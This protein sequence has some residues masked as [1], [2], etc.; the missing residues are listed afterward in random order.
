[1]SPAEE[2]KH[3]CRI[4]LSSQV[5]A[6]LDP[7]PPLAHAHS[8]PT[9]SSAPQ[10]KRR[11]GGGGGH[12]ENLP[13][14]TEKWGQ[15]FGGTQAGRSGRVGFEETGRLLD[16]SDW[17]AGPRFS[18]PE[19]EGQ[20]TAIDAGSEGAVPA[21]SLLSL[22]RRVGLRQDDCVSVCFTLHGGRAGGGGRDDL[23]IPGQNLIF[24]TVQCQTVLGHPSVR[25]VSISLRP[26]GRRVCPSRSIVSL[27]SGSSESPQSASVGRNGN[28]CIFLSRVFC[29][30]CNVRLFPSFFPGLGLAFGLPHPDTAAPKTGVTSCFLRED[31]REILPRCTPVFRAGFPVGRT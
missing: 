7:R 26:I 24:V 22:V 18:I 9:A 2:L 27:T 1:M 13:S 6:N 14:N 31:R 21:G 19:D 15:A 28:M 23:R 29:S 11:G 4:Q 5:Y 25:C 16:E 30:A 17:V 12:T 3:S 20:L 10:R 8:Y